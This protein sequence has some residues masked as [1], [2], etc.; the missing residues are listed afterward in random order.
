MIK[1]V[2]LAEYL[3]DQ[4]YAYEIIEPKNFNPEY[5]DKRFKELIGDGKPVWAVTDSRV[6]LAYE[7]GYSNEG[8]KWQTYK[9]LYFNNSY[10]IIY[11]KEGVCED[12]EDAVGQSLIAFADLIEKYDEPETELEDKDYDDNIT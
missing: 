2:L 8:I 1:N 3:Q 11:D 4:K 6:E 10:R 5:L 9:K 7:I 12:I